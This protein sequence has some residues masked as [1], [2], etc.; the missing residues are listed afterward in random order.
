MKIDDGAGRAAAAVITALLA[1]FGALERE[2]PVIAGL[3]AAP[4][5]TWR[6][7]TCG[8]LRVRPDL[9]G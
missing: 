4:L 5:R 6:G 1:R 7:Q 3:A 2:D 9:L 8:R